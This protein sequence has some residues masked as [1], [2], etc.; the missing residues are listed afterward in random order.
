MWPISSAEI[1]AVSQTV[2]NLIE[3]KPTFSKMKYFLLL[4]VLPCLV[5]TV[6][7]SEDFRFNIEAFNVNEWLD[8]EWQHSEKYEI[9]HTVV[10][11]VPNQSW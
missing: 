9:K 11:S 10:D 8:L 5:L 7:C 6:S 4:A 2:P 3:N 1:V